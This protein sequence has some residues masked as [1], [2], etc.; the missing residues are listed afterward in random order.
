VEREHQ[1]QKAFP[2]S[3]DIMVTS[4]TD[5]EMNSA[6]A[7][8]AFTIVPWWAPEAFTIVPWY[9]SRSDNLSNLTSH[10][11]PFEQNPANPYLFD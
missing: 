9:T 8:E 5:L 2:K 6:R 7:R 1:K 11:F 4:V 10:R 3:L